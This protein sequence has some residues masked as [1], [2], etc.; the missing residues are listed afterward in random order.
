MSRAGFC[1]VALL[2]AG[3]AGP[4]AGRAAEDGAVREAILDSGPYPR[5]YLL[6]LP[7]TL[8][9]AAAPGAGD[10]RLQVVRAMAGKGYATVHTAGA[11]V[12]WQPAPGNESRIRPNMDANYEL[13]DY[14]LLLGTIDLTIE[15]VR[16]SGERAEA[17]VVEHLAPSGL[18]QLVGALIPAGVQAARL[19]PGARTLRL[20]QQT[21]GWRITGEEPPTP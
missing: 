21:A 6:P 15:S 7:A 13:V 5:P 12:T 9:N 11:D 1:A 14:G 2:L 16:V 8:P 10:W 17:R 19:R 3:L 4:A 20:E 18:Y